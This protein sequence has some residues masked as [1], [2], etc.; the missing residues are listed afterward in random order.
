ML[1][2]GGLPKSSQ[3]S[4]STIYQD[5]WLWMEYPPE[6]LSRMCLAKDEEALGRGTGK[7][8]VAY[9]CLRQHHGSRVVG[10]TTG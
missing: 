1:V 4:G 7:E 2:G 10:P 8:Q 5:Q 6:L 9:Q 3:S